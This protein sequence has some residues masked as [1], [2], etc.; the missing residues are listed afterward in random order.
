MSVA[1]LPQAQSYMCVAILAQ[2]IVSSCYCD[3]SCQACRWKRWLR[4]GTI[5]IVAGTSGRLVGTRE[6]LNSKTF[7]SAVVLQGSRPRWRF[8]MQPEWLE[9]LVRQV[10]KAWLSNPKTQ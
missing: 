6:A 7:W 1:I 10:L 4:S 5:A 2:A 8:A 3:S 9:M